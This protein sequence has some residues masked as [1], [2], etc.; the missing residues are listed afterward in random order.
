MVCTIPF[1]ILFIR[2]FL[3]S[4]NIYS[5]ELC[6]IV[7]ICCSGAKFLCE[8]HFIYCFYKSKFSGYFF[9]VDCVLEQ[10]YILILQ[11]SKIC[12]SAC[13]HFYLN[14]QFIPFQYKWIS[15]K[16]RSILIIISMMFIPNAL[17]FLIYFHL[18]K[19]NPYK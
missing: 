16:F 8:K 4:F 2:F 17:P 11:M 9:R 19:R 7:H 13:K 12:Y 14:P 6:F 5:F 18:N 3:L 10:M 1:Q 15:L